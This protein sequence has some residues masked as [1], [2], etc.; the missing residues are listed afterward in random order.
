MEPV[1]TH[2][3][4]K[5]ESSPLGP[6]APSGETRNPPLGPGAP[7]G[8]TRNPPLGPGAPSGETRNP[9]LGP[10]AP[11]GETRNPP[12]GSGAPSGETR[13]PPLGPGAPSG[14]IDVQEEAPSAAP[15]GGRIFVPRQPRAAAAVVRAAP[16]PAGTTA[17]FVV[18][19]DS[20][21]GTAGQ[22]IANAVLAVC[23][24]DFATL[25]GYFGGITPRNLPFNISV[26][27]G[28]NGAS[29]PTCSNTNISIEANSGPLSFM[30]AL[31]VAEEDE[32]FMANFGHGWDCGASNGE[33]LSRVLSNDIYPGVEP[34]DFVSSS[35]WLDAP[36]RPNFVDTTDQSDTNYVSIG[37]SVLFLNWLR[38][39]LNFSWQEIIA[40]GADTLGKTY[41]NLTRK[42][43][44]FAQFSAVLQARFPSGTPSGLT[45]DNPFRGVAID[46]VTLLL[47]R[48][49]VGIEASNFLLLYP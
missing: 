42:T 30:Q 31:V 1:M 36:R 47:L 29:H 33:G 26:I 21:L 3:E 18:S 45:T 38:Y 17:H 2:Q 15:T 16:T 8:E 19:F 28:T 44:G 23:E 37:C 40:A 12:L 46:P 32:V 34:E 41:T 22:A 48:R 20:S 9:P 49:K 7:S 27:P 35:V 4:R 11:S 24:Q 43:D 14:G 5:V 39:E 6:G 25:Q 10:G 13:N